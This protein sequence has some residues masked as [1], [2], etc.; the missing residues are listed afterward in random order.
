VK[1]DSFLLDG[2]AFQVIAGAMHYFRI[3]PGHWRDRI[4]RA[5]RFGLNTIDT[6]VAWNFHSQAP[7]EFANQGW[8]DFGRYLDLIA[9]AGLYAIVRPGPYI[10][11]EW[12]NGGLPVWL[13]ADRGITLRSSDPRYL[14]AVGSYFENVLPVLAPRQITRGGNVLM[15]QVENEYGAYGADKGYLRRLVDMLREG[16]IDVPLF[17][18]DQA[19]DEM[20]S[21]G[22][23]PELLT[24]GTFGSRASERLAAL[25]RAQ[26][27]GPLMC[28][29]FWDGWFDSWGRPHHRTASAA[30]A[31]DLGELLGAGASVSLYMFHGGTNFGLTSG[32]NHIGM[33]LPI[34]TSYDYDAPLAE[35]GTAG[36]K[37][38]AYRSVLKTHVSLPP[39]GLPAAAESP[40]FEAPL[41]VGKPWADADFGP[42]GHYERCP[43]LDEVDPKAAL[44][45]YRTPI[46][47]SDGG[48]ISFAEVR[49]RAYLFFDGHR[50]GTLDRRDGETTIGLP[51]AD[52]M[53]SVLVEDLGRVDYGERLGEAKGLIGPVRTASREIEAWDVT[54]ITE[55]HVAA[56]AP[57]PNQP[58]KPAAG[59]P[60]PGPIVLWGDLKVPAGRDLHLDVTGWGHGIA[61]INGFC[62]GRY[63]SAGPTR[64][65]YVPAPALVD[66][67]NRLLV[68]E[69][70]GAARPA[71]RFVARPD[72]G[73]TEE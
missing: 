46:L 12:T 72:L 6:Y 16:G 11:A 51:N 22:S 33:Y 21:R 59:R 36:A 29:E 53:L 18:A 58:A 63:W 27:S 66:G 48:V 47:A 65:M 40:V 32:A 17:T 55:D 31:R 60:V 37:W 23:L 56:L 64:T 15:V 71:A 13:T 1:D 19:N 45:I 25:R 61:W 52:G 57:E 30:S 2:E 73:H 70:D 69:L 42:A 14:K 49:D 8:R 26:P 24:T 54:A 50:A 5:R 20:L 9:E 44:A 7:G 3:H 62:L 68:L 35:D 67:P 41:A 39:E 4:D 38:A 28:S 34:T 43:S 10:C